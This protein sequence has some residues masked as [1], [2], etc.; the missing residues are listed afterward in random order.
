MSTAANLSPV[1]APNSWPALAWK[2]GLFGTPILI[3]AGLFLLRQ[4]EVARLANHQLPND[5]LVPVFQLVNQDNQ[6]FGTEQL[7]GKIWIADFV[8]TS[9]PGP[10]P[11]ISSR[12]GEL[13]KPL[14]DTDVRLATFSVDPQH[15]TPTVL[16]DYAAR[17][18]AEPGRWNFLTG[19]KGTIYRLARD[20]FKLATMEDPQGPGPIHSTRMVLVDRRGSI[21]GYYDALEAD[22]VTRLLADTHHLLQDQP[23][24]R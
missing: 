5:G 18:N 8:Y 1:R 22:A 10:C 11:M 15:D 6:S 3:A 12:M 16:R 7:R 24:P 21:R 14:K 19:D 9:C 17:L 4:V 13:Q 20:G 2:L 23:A